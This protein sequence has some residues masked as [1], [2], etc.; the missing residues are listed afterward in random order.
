[1]IRG[2]RSISLLLVLSI[3]MT[4]F[5]WPPS[6]VKAF[7]LVENITP[8]TDEKGT[9]T[10]QFKGD[11]NTGRVYLAG[12]FNDWAPRGLELE[13]G[14]N[15]LYSVSLDA[16]TLPYGDQEYK[17]VLNDEDW[18]SGEKNL[19]YQPIAKPVQD[20][21]GNVTFTF[22]AKA[23]VQKVL[24]AGSWDNWQARK[25]LI[26]VEGTNEFKITFSKDE[27]PAGS[28]QYKYIYTPGKEAEN[29][30]PKDNQDL[31]VKGEAPAEAKVTAY[32][33]ADTVA[34]GNSVVI[35]VNVENVTAKTIYFDATSLGG[36]AKVDVSPNLRERAVDVKTDIA[37]G[38]K[39]V[40]VTV[41]DTQG[42]T[43][44][45][46]VTVNV[47]PNTDTEDKLAWD[48]EI[49]YFIVTD[50]FL[51][52][53]SANDPDSTDK[54]HLEAYHGGDFQGII[55][56]VD[57]L[58][59]LG[60]STVWITPIVDNIKTNLMA[61]TGDKQYAYHG[62]WAKDFTKVD[63]S[64]GDL[65]KL[66]EMI[67][68]LHANGIKVM[69]DVVV[70]HAGYG[71]ED[72]NSDLKGMFRAADGSTEPTQSSAGLPDFKTE[73]PEIS[74]K[75][76]GWQADWL[77]KLNKKVDYFR[78]DTVRNVEHETWQRLK[79]EV[80]KIKPDFKMIGEYY[81]GR[82]NANGGYLGTGMMDSVLDFD[83]NNIAKSFI[84]GNV[85]DVENALRAR[86][87]FLSRNITAGQFLSSH[88]EPG[89]LA[90]FLGG[91]K[92]LMKVAASL[93]LTAK[94][95]PVIYYG[96]EIGQSGE[97]SVWKD[98]VWARQG[99]NRYDFDWSKVSA[100][101]DM[102]THYDKMVHI[103]RDYASLFARGDRKTLY[104]DAN[105]SVFSRS[106][107]GKTLLVAI[108]RADSSQKVTFN[109]DTDSFNKFADLYDKDH[110][111][112]GLGGK[113]TVTVPANKDGGT[114]VLLPSK[115]ENI[116]TSKLRVHLNDPNNSG[117][118]LW[119]WP[120][121][122]NG[123]FYKSGSTDDFGQVFDIEVADTYNKFGFI[124]QTEKG[125]KNI[126]ADRYADLKDGRGEIWLRIDDEKVYYERPLTLQEEPLNIKKV[127]MDSFRTLT[128]TLNKP[129][130]MADVRD[131]LKVL[132]AD[133]V[134]QVEKIDRIN[135]S[136]ESTD[137]FLVTLAADLSLEK[138]LEVT[139][140]AAYEGQVLDLK[141]MAI[142]GKIYDDPK[143]DQYYKYDGEL[144]NFFD[145]TST[146]F[147]IWA[148]TALDVK[149]IAFEKGSESARYDM[150]RGYKGV[151][152]YK[153]QGDQKGLEY[154][155]E[156]TVNGK[157]N[158]VVD[159]YAKAVNVNGQHS[160]VATPEASK[161]ERPT[162]KDMKNPIIYELHVRD[163]SVD[164]NSG[165]VNKTN[166]LALTEEGTK[167][168]NG[169]I[170]GLDY[171]KSLGVTHIQLLPIYDFSKSSVDELNEEKYNWG[172]D[173]VNY[174]AVEGSYSSDPTD[175]FKRIE[176]LQ[177]TVDTFHKNNMGVIM[178]VVYN[179]VFSTS[180]HAFD[181]IVPGYYFRLDENGKFRNGTGVGNEVASERSMVRKYIVD[182]TKY[183]AKTFKLDGF[184]FDLMGILDVETINQ[185]YA[186]VSKI[187]PNIFILGEGWNMG[188]HPY[189]DGANQNNAYRMP[190]AAFF[191]DTIRDGIRGNNDPGIGYVN[192][193][194]DKEKGLIQDIKG[195][196][197][198]YS[199]LNA[200][201]VIQYIEA[202]DNY[203]A[204]DQIRKTMPNDSEE[205]ALKRLKIA[206]AIP[207]FSFGTPFIHAGQE[208]A[209]TKGG[210]H[211]SYNLADSVNQ[212][213][214]DRVLKYS[215]NVDYVREL[216]KIRKAYPIFDLKKYDEINAIFETKYD[217]AG[218]VG[219][220]LKNGNQDLYIAHNV[221]GNP[222]TLNVANGTYKVLV[223]DQKADA[224]GLE[225][226]T[227]TNNAVEVPALS[228]LVLVEKED[229]T[230]KTYTIHFPIADAKEQ[231][232]KVHFFTNN[233]QGLTLDFEG[234]DENGFA[235]ASYT[236]KTTVNMA[237]FIVYKD[238]LNDQNKVGTTEDRH[239]ATI[240]QASNEAWVYPNEAKTYYQGPDVEEVAINFA[241]EYV[242]GPDLAYKEE[243][244]L[245]QG[246]EGLERVVSH[247]G[248]ELS[249]KEVRPAAAQIVAV[250][251][252]EVST[253]EVPFDKERVESP[254]LYTFESQVTPGQ[255]GEDKTTTT[256]KVDPATGALIEP[257]SIT[258]RVKD[259][260]NEIT[261]VGT[262]VADKGALDDL[263]KEA[264]ALDLSNKT[265]ESVASLK[266]ALSLAKEV[267][268]NET[269]KQEDVDQAASSLQAAIKGLEDKVQE[270]NGFNK[271][272]KKVVKTVVTVVEVV[273][274][275]VKKTVNKINSFF[276]WLFGY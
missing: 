45:S 200:A 193:A 9:T 184:R 257:S 139:F 102:L 53:N 227:V 157:T 271:F 94:G 243:K 211:N 67:D 150:I 49:I 237:G 26:R 264:E 99:E 142:V 230:E 134:L 220:R 244:T 66:E 218:G 36:S 119:V 44:E 126:E 83:F 17:Y 59:K 162:G 275:E 234:H 174:N 246:V 55:N 229:T 25:E 248:R 194:P 170:T 143:F 58:K 239:F 122:K 177:T 42:N 19:L 72:M 82:Y 253:S 179:H 38:A 255:K 69:I 5:S 56:K 123:A 7:D 173:P 3:L 62:Y 225:T 216:I 224:E 171:L 60:V 187:N 188:H 152:S 204:W 6:K 149:L 103:R 236:Y 85:A 182:S 183:W 46:T 140:S 71:A 73:D 95:Q 31:V 178:D 172:Y 226:I 132:Q 57:H 247:N 10:F 148:P 30:Y 241:T 235:I 141:A 97:V 115:D 195:G 74:A 79:N 100:D 215:D 106:Y 274:T 260:V 133:Q 145:G 192:G 88:D 110:V 176:E 267:N 240:D 116:T 266:E 137:K 61:N 51:N 65:A 80:V 167:A 206:T 43:Y 269:V 129:T 2:K 13:K 199:Y 208:F 190:N 205:N 259:V 77:N 101:N 54:G 40:R 155:Y 86:N 109:Y 24:L 233:D 20:D 64:L 18:Q 121:G 219:Y 127:T 256:Y 84:D 104:T 191:S 221:L 231:G 11:E 222:I 41:V 251:N 163:Y 108:N 120:E 135:G 273:K 12:Y 91:N 48:E 23:D 214:W 93:Q 209:R 96:E 186:E 160:V 81:E 131:D 29:W 37:S 70:N 98:G 35:G 146:E 14:E 125:D 21:Q 124:V 92:A 232:Y 258:E 87:E 156:V 210:E 201:Q 1:M 112:Y 169:Q 249:R 33:S 128:V 185:V 165:M 68:V 196:Q 28:Y 52:G 76:V 228:T 4:M 166:F 203:T 164:P 197:G 276:S 78:I 111:E 270:E 175:P 261:T 252:V 198:R 27:L 263:I 181:Q 238:Q 153:L 114:A 245:T 32:A 159:P 39:D 254:D 90:H 268:E 107:N 265:D 272:I 16:K 136:D 217:G 138:A 50:R 158:L 168:T 113:V 63:P 202:H 22:F 213:D 89:F 242:A 212:F 207:M 180:E 144:G 47:T 118:G 223:K 189:N 105:V 34:A 117:Y 151:Y 130:S 250:G 147:R 154:M 161:V 8:V 75:V 262:R 15:N